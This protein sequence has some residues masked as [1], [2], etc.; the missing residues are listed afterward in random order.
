MLHSA[1]PNNGHFILKSCASRSAIMALLVVGVLL[2]P[3]SHAAFVDAFAL[4]ADAASDLPR[5]DYFPEL[6]TDGAGNWVAIW[7][8]FVDP[9]E[10][11]I[12]VARSTNNGATWTSPLAIN[13]NPGSNTDQNWKPHIA[14]DGAGNWVAVWYS[15]DTLGA[16]VGSDD[17]ILVSRSTDAGATWTAPVALNSSAISD[18]GAD[19]DPQIVTDGVGNWVAVWTSLDPLGGTVGSDADILMARSTNN[20]ATWTTVSALNTNAASD[21]EED[22]SPRIAT[23]TAGQWVTVWSSKNTLSGTIG[24]DY[25]ILSARSSNNGATWTAP[26]ALNSSA[27]TDSGSDDRPSI[28]TD[29]SGNWVVTWKSNDSLGGTIGTDYDILV[30]RSTNGGSTWSTV[31]AL[32]TNAPDPLK[33]DHDPR[34]VSDKS[35]KWLV[36]WKSNDTLGNTL[37]TDDDILQAQSTDGG[38]TWSTA[39]ALYGSAASDSGNDSV[40]SLATDAAG[41]WVALCHSEDTLGNSIGADLD[42]LVTYDAPVSLATVWV[43]FAYSGVE[44]GSSSQPYNTLRE[45]LAAVNLGGTIKIKGNTAENTTDETATITTAMTLTAENGTVRLGDTGA[46]LLN[47]DMN[48]KSDSLTQSARAESPTIE[49]AL[50][51]VLNALESSALST[52][53]TIDPSTDLIGAPRAVFEAHMPLTRNAD[54]NM[55][56]A[57]DTVL[58]LRI[59]SV[60]ALEP[61]TIEAFVSAVR[62]EG[63]RADWTP[64]DGESMNDLWVLVYNEDGWELHSQVSVSA[65]AETTSHD[66]VATERVTVSVESAASGALT[67]TEVSTAPG[68]QAL[69]PATPIYSIGPEQVFSEP[70]QINV[71]LPKGAMAQDIVINYLHQ[72]DI[73]PTWH[74]SEEVVGWLERG[75]VSVI[76]NATDATLSFKVHHGGIF[77]ILWRFEAGE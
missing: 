60:E 72:S 45:G 41:H 56:A 16:T 50:R 4:N 7:N 55:V 9:T 5:D 29:G 32:N 54:G 42:I 67:L 12:F 51:R 27:G 2:A 35:G 13:N 64:V 30:S 3:L 76:Q 17:D 24:D 68:E 31:Q 15:S 75:S 8:S 69:L 73:E 20:G 38:A 26:T 33:G 10:G 34:V 52:E 14:T 43:D 25:D 28:D 39:Q 11:D 70:Q 58:G 19:R 77:Q 46:K 62:S 53:L 47:L 66:I 71:S 61:E 6:C 1:Y 57:P 40:P 59:R 36:V 65:E 23:H 44:D 18:T 21:S 49:S 63:V 74:P 48:A 37:G 22:V